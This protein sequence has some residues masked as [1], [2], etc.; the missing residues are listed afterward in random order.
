MQQNA[1]VWYAE[2][3]KPLWAPE[4]WIFGPVWSVLYLI[5]A[6]SFGYVLYAAYTKRIPRWIVVPFA[7][8]LFFNAIFSPL[9]FGLQNLLLATIDIFLVLGTLIWALYV[10]WP[11]ARWVTFVNIP[12]TL[13]VAFATVLQVTITMLNW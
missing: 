1:Y 7:L 9:Q 12:Y 8:N 13:W 5:I 10:I 6:V 3:S 2:L 11:Y 4:A